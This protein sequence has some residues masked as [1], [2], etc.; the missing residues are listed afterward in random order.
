MYKAILRLFFYQISY[1]KMIMT[2]ETRW[3][4]QSKSKILLGLT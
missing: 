4:H 3:S 1:Y 2:Q